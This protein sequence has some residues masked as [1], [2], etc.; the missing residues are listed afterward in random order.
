MSAT[1]PGG[2][3]GCRGLKVLVCTGKADPL[4]DEGVA[5][6]D[7]LVAAGAAVTHAEFRAGHCSGW[8][9]DKAEREKAQAAAASYLSA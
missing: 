2:L 6:R 4:H 5:V 7:A 9:F 1:A 8:Y 3:D